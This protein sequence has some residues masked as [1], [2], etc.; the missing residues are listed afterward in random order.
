MKDFKLFKCMRLVI[1]LL[2]MM[3]SMQAM[4][5]HVVSGTVTDQNGEPL[6]GASVS[7]KGSTHSARTNE[8]GQYGIT[9]GNDNS[10]VLVFHYVGMESF[11]TV[12]KNRIRIDVTLH[13]ATNQLDEVAVVSTGYQRLSRERSTAAF[14]FVDSTKLNTQ[15]HRDLLSSLEGQVAGLQIN[16]NPYTGSMSPILRGVGTFSNDVGTQPL[17]VVDNMPT[18][19]TL[20][21]INPYNVES[22]TVLKDAAAASIYGALAANGVIVVTTKQAKNIGTQVT[23]NADW[24]IT[25]KPNFS[26]LNLASTSDIIDYQTDAFKSMVADAGSAANVLGSYKSGY[27]NPLFQLFLDK[28]N[29]K[30]SESDMNSTIDKWRNNDYYEQFRDNA[31]RTAIT[32]RY[33]VSLS[34]KAGKSNHYLSF[35]FENDKNRTINDKSNSFALYYKSYYSIN[36]WLKLT[37]GIDAKLS[38]SNTPVDYS[39]T[40]QQRYEQI[41]DADG[42]RYTSPYVS[43]SGFAGSAYNGSIVS[44]YE[45]VSPYQSFGFNVLDALGEG[46]T[47]RHNV[48]MRPF[49]S[50]EAKFLSYFKYN[51]MYQ[52]EWKQSKSERY[53]AADSYMMRMTHNA[54]IDTDGISHLPSGGRYYQTEGNTNS[55]TLRNQINF[56]KAWKN[57]NVSAIVGMEFRENKS[58]RLIEQMMYGYD[59]QTLTSDRMDWEALYEGVGNSALSG[60][61]ITMSGLST[62]QQE[63]RHR[64]ASLYANASYSYRSRYNVSG[65]IRWDEA[66]LFGLDVDTQHHP[67]WSLGAGWLVTEEQFMK[68][69]SWLDYLKLRMTYGVNGNVDQSS[70]TYFVVRQKTQSNPIKSTYLNYEDDDL[71]NPKLRWEK[72]ATYNIGIDFRILN[73]LFNGTV[74]YYNR[75]AS[76]LLVRRYMDPT[77]GAESRVVNNGE[78][79]NRGLELTLNANI[80]RTKDWNFSAGMTLA[81]NSNKMLKVDHSESDVASSFVASPTNYFIEGTSYNTLW[82]YRIDR[83]ENGYPIAVDKD[84]NDLVTFNEDGTVKTITYTSSL[85]GTDDLVNMGTLTPKYHGSVSLNLRYKQFELNTL[86]IYS[87]GNKMRAEVVDMDDAAG[88]ETGAT[89]N[90]RWSAADPNG[91][92]RMYL[93]MPKSVKTYASTFQDWWQYGDI[94][95]K[96]ADYVKLRSID[97]AYSLSPYLCSKIGLASL[98]L[99]LQVNNLFTWSKAGHDIDPECYS[100]NSGTRVL[101]MPKTFSIGVSTSF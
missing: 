50:L 16:T 45:G 58:P 97:L 66:D 8:K 57:N 5:Q 89:I 29:G 4:A 55:Y 63:I 19:M 42:N 37:A 93:D 43:V 80:L 18:N 11:Q 96:D 22:V 17:I 7:V 2:L 12:T 46:I 30:V 28:E 82:A 94:N 72:T 84:G 35:D 78:M 81:N 68:N 77:L 56:D 27:Y 75:H 23:V 20:D 86:F 98:K 9:V 26:S 1:G 13:D 14:G 10:S 92:V 21:Q 15:M 36:K 90:N 24:F 62:T 64:Y 25:C 47:K 85:K 31:W 88:R 95:V 69:I 52:Y 49:V 79:R 54:M 91:T 33:N 44:Q 76:D 100:L 73:N 70:T 51:F 38:K 83:I 6:F 39:Y 74:E 87:G 67:L 71:P 32:Q 48:S 34:Q 59:P 60:S 99:K 41:L 40:T 3:G 53:D 65:S 61:R 101:A